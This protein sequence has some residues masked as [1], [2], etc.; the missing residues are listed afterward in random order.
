MNISSMLFL[1]AFLPAVF[2]LDRLCMGSRGMLKLKN[3]LLLLAS[4]LFYAWGEPA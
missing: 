4:L 2:L 3:V 1:T